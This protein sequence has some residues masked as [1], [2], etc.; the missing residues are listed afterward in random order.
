[1]GTIDRSQIEEFLD[2]AAGLQHGPT[3]IGLLEEAVKLA[4]MLADIPLG[5]RARS[6][7][8]EAAN[9][10]GAPEKVMVAFSWCLAQLDKNPDHFP[11]YETLWEYKWVIGCMPSFVRLSRAQIEAAFDDFRSRVER[12]NYGTRPVYKLRASVACKMG[13]LDDYHKAHALWL[14]TKRG[15]FSDCSTCDL[16][17]EVEYLALTGEDEQAIERARPLLEG[18]A[19]CEEEPH[20]TLALVLQPLVRLGRLEEAM[21]YHRKGYRL[22]S[23]NRSFLQAAAKHLEFLALTDN[24]AKATKLFEAHLPW[25]LET[26]DDLD[27]FQFSM[28]ARFL[29][30]RLQTSGKK[31]VKLRLPS[32]FPLFDESGKYGVPDL[33]DWLRTDAADLARRFDARNGNDSFARENEASLALESLVKPFPLSGRAK[34]NPTA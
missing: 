14:K 5:F 15:M 29:F 33:A 8:V 12:A 34:E 10:G 17:T 1:M 28:A 7:L 2:Q 26:F 30:D 23:R 21:T 16:S 13:N 11:L 6:R 20:T 32:T 24:L 9:F 22:I 25:A 31:T 3:Q 4:D 18:K 27:R 19:R